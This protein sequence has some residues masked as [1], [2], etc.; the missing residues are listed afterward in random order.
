MIPNFFRKKPIPD[1]LPAEME[2]IVEELK[3]L[4]S[5]EECL[6][7][8]YEIMIGRY[9]GYRFR[10]YWQLHKAWEMDLEKIWKKT[11]FLHCHAMNYL[12]RVLLVKSGWFQD[13]DIQLKYSLVWYVSPHQYLRVKIED[14]KF[15][16]VDVWNYNYGKKFGDY[17][18]GFH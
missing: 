18:H 12:L 3:H 2:Q 8:A 11:G 4:N 16:N 1:K 14:N 13:D 5:K 15:V 10:T 17:A 6:K 9:R 7:R